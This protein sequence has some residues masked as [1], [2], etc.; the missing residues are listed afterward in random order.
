VTS[1]SSSSV[2]TFCA[3]GRINLIGEHTDYNGGFAMPAAIGLTTRV[4]MSPREDH[5][6]S[7]RASDFAESADFEL[8]DSVPPT[9][10]HWSDY[11]RGV[12]FVLESA[13]FCLKGADLVINSEVPVGAGLS[14]SA[15]LEVSTALALLAR[16][17]IEIDKRELALFC[18]RAEND[19]VGVRCGV[20]DQLASCMGRKDHA[21]LLDC[22]SLEIDYV[23]IPARV[24]MVICNSM[25]K[26][27]LASGEYN[28]RRLECE[29]AVEALA[30]FNPDIRQLRDATTADLKHLQGVSG[31]TLFRRARHVITENQRTLDGAAALRNSDLKTFGELMIASHE[32]LRDDFEVSCRE[33]D[34]LVE[35]AVRQPGVYGSRMMGGG[36]G[37]C[38]ISAVD[39]SFASVF[40][41]DVTREYLART[42]I[43]CATYVLEASAGAGECI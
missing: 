26:H 34:T 13:G 39:Q 21:L 35:I 1:S 17:E 31:G 30:R 8:G 9:K 12:A 29:Q 10:P 6:V 20:M 2:R 16:S 37:G 3:P 15:A 18:Q 36:F 14:S 25:V 41:E 19:F 7:V 40:Q 28:L 4:L 24:R 23:P 22:K 33:L 32:S 11:I 38:T 43:K 27:A 5:R 42:G